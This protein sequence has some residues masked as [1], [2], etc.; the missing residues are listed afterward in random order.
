MNDN[1]LPLYIQ[2]A[3]DLKFKINS[4]EWK[5]EDQIPTEYE[6]CTIYDVSRITIRKAIDQLVNEGLL[7]RKRAVGTFVQAKELEVKETVVK[8][9]TQEMNNLGR[10][11]HTLEAKV[12][13]V[14]AT[15]KIANFLNINEGDPVLNLQRIFGTEELAF[16]FFDTYFTYETFFST[17]S[18]DYYGSFYEYLKTFDIIVDSVKEYVEAVNPSEY[19]VEVLKIDTNTPILKRVRITQQLGKQFHEYSECFY[20]GSEY[21]Y[22]VNDFT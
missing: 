13:M 14:K 2:I 7:Y 3:S 9:F 12:N 11:V 16:A 19:L 22:Y 17:S 4:G 8:S 10:K 20:I 5:V 18:E 6:L 21:R 15:A 1:R